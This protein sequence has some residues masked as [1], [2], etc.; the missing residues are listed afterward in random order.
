[1]A[2]RPEIPPANP[3]LP[4]ALAFA[5]LIAMTSL[6]VNGE[7]FKSLPWCI[8]TLIASYLTTWRIPRV[9]ALEWALRAIVYGLILLI[10]GLPKESIVFWYIKFEY[11]DRI[12]YLIAAELALRAWRKPDPARVT[13]DRGDV[14]LLSALLM[15]ASANTYDRRW[16][17]LFAPAYTLFLLLSLRSLTPAPTRKRPTLTMLRVIA[18]VTA[19]ALGFTGIY[20]ITRYDRK[21][22]TWAMSLLRQNDNRRTEIGLSSAPRLQA[23]FNP[24]ASMTRMLLIDGPVG[25]RHLRAMAF[26]TYDGTA[27]RPNL[28]DR[29]FQT[30]PPGDLQ[31]SSTGTRLHV[32][33]LEDTMDLLLLPLESAAVESPG[34][35]ERDALGS[36]RTRDS[37][38]FPSYDLIVPPRPPPEGVVSLPPNHSQRQRLLAIP[39]E[40]DARVTALARQVAGAG[41]PATRLARIQLH[42]R[43]AHQYSLSFQPEG[44]PLSDFV[45]NGRSAHCQYFA[46]AM[47]IMA[48]AAGIPARFVTGYYAHEA[49]GEGRTVVRDRDAHAWAECWLDGAG[50]VAVDATPA[51]GLP[52]ALFPNPSAWQKFRERAADFPAAARAWLAN[53]SRKT[54]ATAIAIITAVWLLVWTLRKLRTGRPRKRP[55]PRG[56]DPPAPDLAAIGKRFEKL[57]TNRGVPCAA[58]RT[59]R[60]HVRVLTDG[61]NYLAFV[62]AYDDARFG[63]A[64]GKSLEGVRQSL[65]NLERQT[66]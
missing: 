39:P 53:L 20:L 11:T 56:C 59:W 47:V 63:G 28:S 18:G 66:V 14:L 64:G 52:D 29:E 49:Y 7:S 3:R 22:S 42:L 23:V 17:Q 34:P 38:T 44:E 19:L 37:E 10:V 35:V 8:A 33:R 27:W 48:R 55:P 24:P 40:I 50:W 6:Y 36:L 16:M 15:T 54:I 13:R 58:G 45:L 62:D 61:P 5:S 57:L 31:K 25:E 12:G 51:S 41:D 1:M 46:S 9:R 21:I 43:S 60:E 65:Q 2:T 32:T 30:V 26:D 4:I